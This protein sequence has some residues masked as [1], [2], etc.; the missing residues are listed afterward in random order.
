MFYIVTRAAYMRLLKSLSIL[1]LRPRESPRDVLGSAKDG[2]SVGAMRFAK[3]VVQS[4]KKLGAH[5]A[6][7][8]EPV[9]VV[10]FFSGPVGVQDHPVGARHAE[11][12]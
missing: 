6:C 10:Y 4:R 8:H 2:I 3:Q 1:G 12:L 9:V 5:L 7:V 11:E